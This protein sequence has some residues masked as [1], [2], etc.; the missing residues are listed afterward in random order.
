MLLYYTIIKIIDNGNLLISDFLIINICSWKSKHISKKKSLTI[1]IK[2]LLFYYITINKL[3]G[4][5]F[6]ISFFL[7]R[8]IY[9]YKNKYANIK[10]NNNM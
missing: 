9:S 3:N 2:S 8:N 1:A 4:Y 10:N 7:I 5:N 6:Y